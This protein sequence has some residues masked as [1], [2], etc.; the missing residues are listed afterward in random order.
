MATHWSNESGQKS[1]QTVDVVVVG[2]CVPHPDCHGEP[3]ANE[4]QLSTPIVI[5][6]RS[7]EH[8][9]K[10]G[11]QPVYCRCEPFEIRSVANQVELQQMDIYGRVWRHY[12]YETEGV[13]HKFLVEYI[14]WHTR[15]WTILNCKITHLSFTHIKYFYIFIYI[16]QMKLYPPNERISYIYLKNWTHRVKIFNTTQ[17][18]EKYLLFMKIGYDHKGNVTH[19]G[20]LTG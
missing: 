11:S 5:D 15:S 7:E 14:G 19:W 9:S 18:C 8:V 1:D 13:V 4:K 20:L 17:K 16:I 12:M 3:G 10:Q 2:E 6:E